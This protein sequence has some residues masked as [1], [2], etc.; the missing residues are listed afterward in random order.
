MCIRDSKRHL[1][2][3]PQ[4]HR[5]PCQTEG[6]CK[7]HHQH[8]QVASER[9]QVSSRPGDHTGTSNISSRVFRSSALLHNLQHSWC[10]DF[11]KCFI[12]RGLVQPPGPRQICCGVCSQ[13]LWGKTGIQSCIASRNN[14]GTDQQCVATHILCCNKPQPMMLL[15]AKRIAL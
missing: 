15:N 7:S 11:Q 6:A 4:L 3:P 9:R 2:Q 14:Y 1:R 5:S 13:R 12:H 8:G 10:Q